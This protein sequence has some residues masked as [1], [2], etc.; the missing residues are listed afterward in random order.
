MGTKLNIEY[1]RSEFDKYGYTLLSEE[2]TN[3]NTKLN[4]RCP[5]NHYHDITWHNWRHGY[6]CPS[7]AGNIKLT[8]EQVSESFTKYG[9]KLL[10]KE[11]I[12]N[13]TKLN[14]QCSKY[15]EHSI[16][17][18]DWQQGHRC[19]TCA[20]L[21]KLTL[22]QVRYSFESTGYSLLSKEYKNSK[23]K[24]DYRCSEGHEHEIT[25][26]NWMMGCR[27]PTCSD[28]N[29]FGSGNPRW[30]GGV[31]YEPYCPI[32]SDNEYK[33]DIR[34]RDGNKCL[35]P[36]CWK[37]DKVLSVHHIDY[38]KKSCSP[39]NL[40]TICRSC[41]ARAN[42]HR[43]WHTAWYQALMYRRYKYEY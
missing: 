11:Y 10:S 21:T 36:D 30:L 2:Y 8:I 35:N 17:F 41:N 24:L 34:L 1:V 42:F 6:R 28:L 39:K 7:C 19:P 18:N 25:W 40:I 12:G 38:N 27:C 43:E 29:R 4:Y 33:K 20:G 16:K 32:W 9:Y 13:K 22:D 14:Y 31:S 23:T 15:H 37:K 26:G 5:K 3:N